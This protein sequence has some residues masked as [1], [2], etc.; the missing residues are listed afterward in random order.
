MKLSSHRIS[1]LWLSILTLAGFVTSAS[2][3]V[4]V[5]KL[6]FEAQRSVNLEFYNEGYF[7]A[8]AS[9]GSGSFIFMV[10][11]PKEKSY[12]PTT[13]GRLYPALTSRD[14]L[15]WIV[16]ATSGAAGGTTTAATGASYVCFGSVN[17][18]V[19][20]TG[21]TFDIRT[22]ISPSMRGSVN[23]FSDESAS[24]PA[25]DGTMSFAAV[26]DFK[27][28]YDKD[29]TS[30]ANKNGQSVSQVITSLIAELKRRGFKPEVR[31]P[32]SGGGSGS[33]G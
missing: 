3:Q 12:S 32:S 16:S 7:V 20:L 18:S 10:N 13:P 28:S 9:G 29:R 24:G 23:A 27:M 31:E 26:L 30:A 5:Y 8:P 22:K 33:G 21:P 2:A 17:Q 25:D 15:K 1:A 19:R 11:T 14:S 6:G 4:L